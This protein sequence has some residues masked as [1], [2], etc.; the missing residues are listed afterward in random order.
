MVKKL[1]R[2]EIESTFKYFV[3]VFIM[4]LVGAGIFTSLMVTSLNVSITSSA[5]EMVI[6]IVVILL[7]ALVIASLVLSVLGLLQVMY[8]TLYSVT[9][10]RQFTYPITSSQRILVKV[11]TSLFWIFVTFIYVLLML[12]LSILLSALFSFQFNEILNMINFNFIEALLSID[13]AFTSLFN[14]S[15]VSNLVLQLMLILVAGAFANSSYIRKNRS[16]VAFVVYMLTSILI[17][18]LYSITIYMITGIQSL[19]LGSIFIAGIVEIPYGG[20]A[21]GVIINVL[22][23]VAAYFTTVWL[24]ERKLEIL[25]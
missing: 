7:V 18:S 21:L 11:I 25:N 4:G 16:I 6:A 3:P 1:I 22:F 15:V 20:M 24:W 14:L 17:D 23:I 9:G 8:K 5:F 12:G 19:G 10:Y 2:N 13:L